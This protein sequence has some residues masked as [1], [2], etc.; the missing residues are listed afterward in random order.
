LRPCFDSILWIQ[1]DRGLQALHDSLEDLA[2]P[3]DMFPVVPPLDE[4]DVVAVA[5][6]NELLGQHGH[7][8]LLVIDGLDILFTDT[9]GP[10][11]KRVFKP[12]QGVAANNNCAIIGT[13][14]GPKR[15]GTRPV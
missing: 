2:L 5:K 11:I 4:V 14:G 3:E 1:Q 15:Q 6:I 7:P 13:W 9:R 8:T 10:A 12:L